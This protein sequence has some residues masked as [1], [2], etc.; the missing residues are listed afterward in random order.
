MRQSK[1][2]PS[3]IPESEDHNV[4]LVVDDFSYI[5]RC[6]RETDVETTDLETVI[7]PIQQPGPGCQLQHGR[8]LGA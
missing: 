3:I 2:A 7:G 6:W 1:W 5:G 8:G 4:Y